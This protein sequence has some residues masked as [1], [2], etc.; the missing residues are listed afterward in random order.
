MLQID[1]ADKSFND[2][3]LH[4]Y[5]GIDVMLGNCLDEMEYSC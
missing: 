2:D 5:H 1:Q 3:S 4:I